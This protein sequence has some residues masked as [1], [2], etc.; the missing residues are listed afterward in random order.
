MTEIDTQ[1]IKGYQLVGDKRDMPAEHTCSNCIKRESCYHRQ[2]YQH[3]NHTG[4][5]L[6]WAGEKYPQIT[7]WR[8][9]ND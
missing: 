8:D 4:I 2:Y 6:L 9:I 1:Q 3:V 5:C 7:R